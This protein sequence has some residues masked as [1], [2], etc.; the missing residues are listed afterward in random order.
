MLFVYVG[1]SLGEINL[2]LLLKCLHARVQ[3]SLS[4]HPICHLA[5]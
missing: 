5:R 2:H 1:N 3:F 4:S